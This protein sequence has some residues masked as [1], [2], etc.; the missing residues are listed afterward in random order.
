MRALRQDRERGFSA[1]EICG[2]QS[3]SSQVRAIGLA[4]DAYPRGY[5]STTT[6]G[7]GFC[8]LVTQTREGKPE[9]KWFQIWA[10]SACLGMSNNFR[11]Y[12]VQLGSG[13]IGLSQMP[14]GD[15]NY[16]A[17]MAVLRAWSPAL[18]ISLTEQVEMTAAGADNL[19]LDLN[20]SGIE[21]CH[22]PIPDYGVPGEIQEGL[23]PN[24]AKQA[25][26]YLSQGRRVLVHCKG[27][28]GRSGMIVL[29]LMIEN[30]EHSED[31]L[32]R[33][34]TARPCAIETNAQLAW[35]KGAKMH[36]MSIGKGYD[37]NKKNEI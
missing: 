29:R 19:H 35:S 12:V 2:M 4:I 32:V 14:G 1:R 37:P 30:G 16:C 33:L 34:R 26:A 21:C 28:C 27:G 36:G 9:R 7:T 11:I 23:W 10:G 18:V 3:H 6:L 13:F 20:A 15:R 22:F 31:A 24:L 5:L 25:H 8:R 17:D